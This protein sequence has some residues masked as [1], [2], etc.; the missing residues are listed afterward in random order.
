MESF[1]YHLGDEKVKQ[2]LSNAIIDR[3]A[4]RRFKDLATALGVIEDWYSFKRECYKDIVIEWCEVNGLV[5]E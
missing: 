5:H 2:Q 3:G 4:F 1:C